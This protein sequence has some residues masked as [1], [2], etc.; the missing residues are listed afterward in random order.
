MLCVS[1]CSNK[2]YIRGR[3]WFWFVHS[4]TSANLLCVRI[5]IRLDRRRRQSAGGD[6]IFAAIRSLPVASHPCTARGIKNRAWQ[7]RNLPRNHH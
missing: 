7:S 6:R 4:N 1:V 2:N 5:L 3:I